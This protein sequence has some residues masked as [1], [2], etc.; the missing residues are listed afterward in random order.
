[1]LKLKT[2]R[3]TVL[4][5]DQIGMVSGGD[6]DEGGVNSDVCESNICYS[7]VCESNGCVSNMCVSNGCY[8]YQC[9]SQGCLSQGECHTEQ[10]LRCE[11]SF[12]VF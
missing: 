9:V 2:R 4:T 7:D 8:S 1:M 3:V 10:S 12:T 11:P 6:G 5:S